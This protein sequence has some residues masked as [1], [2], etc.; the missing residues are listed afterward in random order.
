MANLNETDAFERQTAVAD[1]LTHVF[2][3]SHTDWRD[4]ADTL[5]DQLRRRGYEIIHIPDEDE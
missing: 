2:H 4:R 5:I 3:A 1:S